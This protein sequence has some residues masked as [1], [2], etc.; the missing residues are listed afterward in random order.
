MKLATEREELDNGYGC[1][2]KGHEIVR[3][4]WVVV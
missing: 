3:F 4:N 1:R 2:T